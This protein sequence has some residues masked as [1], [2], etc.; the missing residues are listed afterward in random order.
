MKSNRSVMNKHS[1][2]DVGTPKVVKNHKPI[3]KNMAIFG[4]RNKR[5]GGSDGERK[6]Y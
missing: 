5:S 3:G 4:M 1:K 2:R 6:G